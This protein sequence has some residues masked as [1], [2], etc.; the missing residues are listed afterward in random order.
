MAETIIESRA[1]ILKDL[2]GQEIGGSDD[3]DQRITLLK[4]KGI[5]DK[6]KERRS[7]QAIYRILSEIAFPLFKETQAKCEK[8]NEFFLENTNRAYYVNSNNHI[9]QVKSQDHSWE[10]VR[11][12]WLAEQFLTQ[13]GDV[14][15][16]HFEYKLNG[17]KE[18]TH[19]QSLYI[20]ITFW[21]D[22]YNYEI[23]TVG[24]RQGAGIKKAYNDGL[25]TEEKHGIITKTIDPVL[26]QIE[27]YLENK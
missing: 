26:N 11:E 9:F 22:D 7:P 3:L 24:E 12:N 25:S 14:R 15:N 19:A 23:L 21:F 20:R 16:F 13:Q 4:K 18:S 27:K 5:M 6:V 17:F 8:L 10:M 1:A 2:E